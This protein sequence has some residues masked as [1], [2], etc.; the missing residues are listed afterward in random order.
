MNNE[1]GLVITPWQSETGENGV[2]INFPLSTFPQN[3]FNALMACIKRNRE[4]GKC[5][6]ADLL[7][8]KKGIMTIHIIG[9]SDCVPEFI[10]LI[11]LEMLTANFIPFPEINKDLTEKIK[12]LTSP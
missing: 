9:I 5:F 3:H 10:Q 4:S 7:H 2:E 1:T 12:D 11:D 6:V 8:D